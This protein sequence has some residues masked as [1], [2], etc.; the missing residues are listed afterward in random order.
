MREVGIGSGVHPVYLTLEHIARREDDASHL[1]EMIAKNARTME[2]IGDVHRKELEVT[3]PLLNAELDPVYSDLRALGL[4]FLGLPDARA[5]T[6][7]EYRHA[8]P[9]LVEHLRRP[10]CDDALGIIALSLQVRMPEVK[11]AWPELLAIYL[12]ARD[13]HGIRRP[14][15]TVPRTFLFKMHLANVLL[16]AYRPKHLNDMIALLKDPDQ[17][18][19][20]TLL[21]SAL[22][23]SK[24]PKAIQTIND[25]AD[26][27][28]FATEIA[29]RRKV[30][31]KKLQ[32]I[33]GA[34]A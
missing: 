16:Y 8:I 10:Y 9:I 22:R 27:P 30:K 12:K 7:P 18:D 25:L 14:G 6:M 21:L 23:R 13:G 29:H 19:A 24:D 28:V 26:D 1:A 5:M 33:H 17:G 15:E 34:S 31:K 32:R 3:I 11:S 4:V 2:S 20:R